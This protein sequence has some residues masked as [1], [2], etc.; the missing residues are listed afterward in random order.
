MELLTHD[1]ECD[2]PR[3]MCQVSSS[4]LLSLP[5]LSL[6]CCILSCH[7]VHCIIMFSKLASV[8]VSSFSLLFVLSPD[9]L[10]RARGTV[11]NPLC[12]VHQT[13]L[14]R[15]PESC[16]GPNPDCRYRCVRIIPKHPENISVF[17]FGFP[18]YFSRPSDHDQTD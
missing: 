18:I 13:P 15:V 10:A 1:G 7:H 9:T 11:R 6:A 17:L 14:A 2:A 16:P 5:C 3:P 8:P 12:S 4:Y